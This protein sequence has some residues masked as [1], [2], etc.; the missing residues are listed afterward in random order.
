MKLIGGA[1]TTTVTCPVCGSK[2]SQPVSKIRQ[3][4]AMLCPECKALFV[5][6]R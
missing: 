3:E 4:Q 5:V 2:S 6:P 1:A